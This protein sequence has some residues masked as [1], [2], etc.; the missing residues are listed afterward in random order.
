MP[1][2]KKLP[3]RI[4]ARRKDVRGAGL[5]EHGVTIDAP[6]P[7]TQ[8]TGLESKGAQKVVGRNRDARTDAPTRV[9]AKNASVGLGLFE[10]ARANIKRGVTVALLGIALS[11][12]GLAHALDLNAAITANQLHQQ[13]SHR[14]STATA[15]K[16]LSAATS[17]PPQGVPQALMPG[18]VVALPDSTIEVRAPEGGRDTP[19]SLALA[20]GSRLDVTRPRTDLPSRMIEREGFVVEHGD[21]PGDYYCEHALFVQQRF[22]FEAGILKNAH[23][24]SLTG[25]LHVPHDEHTGKPADEPI[26][27]SQRYARHREVVGAAVFG[28]FHDAKKMTQ[29]D[30]R[31]LITG[32]G[33]FM[34]ITNNPAGGFVSDRSNIDAA[35]RHAFGDAL[36]SAQGELLA[37]RSGAQ[38]DETMTLAYTVKDGTGTRR[39]IVTA[40]Q[41]DV[42]DHELNPN[43][44]GSLI[45]A[46]RAVRPH[47]MLSLG[48]HGG[49]SF[50]VEHHADDGGLA[51]HVDGVMSH[52]GS[53]SPSQAFL[54]NY[55]LARAIWQKVQTSAVP[56]PRV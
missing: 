54:D 17:P 25:F 20:D 22:A 52:A 9:G 4:E 50:K 28:F 51:T 32:Y 31:I 55:A 5:V 46:M 3:P 10:R 18:E 19:L 36:V 23:G 11:Q 1:I 39:L 29:E 56:A 24:E 34:S 47:A 33:P 21:D 12:S 30:V 8:L 49:I 43:D 26:D 2:D 13:T 45:G 42:A 15:A 14:I 41:L 37:D 6:A 38:G 53:K 27:A 44:P 40:E 35:V 16:A 7:A 48:V